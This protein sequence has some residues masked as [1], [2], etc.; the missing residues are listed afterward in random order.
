MCK[1]KLVNKVS[2]KSCVAKVST[3]N[4]RGFNDPIKQLNLVNDMDIHGIPL[5]AIQETKMSDTNVIP[6]KSDKGN[7]YSLYT[8]H[9]DNK[10]HGVGF[11]VS[12]SL[13]VK[14]NPVNNRLCYL[15]LQSDNE[16]TYIINAY[17]PTLPKS[18]KNPV[19]REN[20]Y[21]ELQSVLELCKKKDI[22]FICGDF[23]A[24][25]GSE[26]ENYSDIMG[27]FGRGKANS[28]GECLLEFC[29]RNEFILANTTFQ[30]KMSHITTWTANFNYPNTNIPV[31]NQID[32]ILINKPHRYIINNCR[33]Y[34]NI[35]TSSDH[36]PVIADL[37][38]KWIRKPG[39]T[40]KGEKPIDVE[41]LRYPEKTNAYQNLVKDKLSN[42]HN[43]S[44]PEEIWNNIVSACKTSAKEVAGEK[45]RENQVKSKRDLN[46]QRL[47]E[48]QK[49][50]GR[51]REAAKDADVRKRLQQE[52]NK[53]MRE[54]KDEVRLREE[55]KILQDIEEIEKVKDDSN[56]MYKAVRKSVRKKKQKLVIKTKDGLTCDVEEATNEI[57]KFFKDMFN[58]DH[59]IDDLAEPTP[60]N[61]P[62]A[63]SEVKK[64]IKSLKFNKSPGIDNLTSEELKMGPEELFESIASLL[65]TIA[66]TGKYPQVLNHG[67]LI[68]LQKPG[69]AKG[70]VGNLRPVILS[71]LLRKVIAICMLNR[72]TSKL[73]GESNIPV[74]QAAYR[75]GRS[76]TEH[77]L[78]LKLL[79]EKA[80]SADSYEIIILLKDLSKAFDN[81]NRSKLI[82]ILK[83]I[84]NPDELHII[85][86]LLKDTSLQI[87]YDGKLGETFKSD[88]GVPQGDGLSPIL[89]TLY[90]AKAL[91]PTSNYLSATLS[92]HS[93]STST[94]KITESINT[95]KLQ[96]SKPVGDHTYSYI[97]PSENTTDHQSLYQKP[98]PD[99]PPLP[100]HLTDHDYSSP[101]PSFNLQQQY[102]DDTCWASTDDSKINHIM[103]TV[104]TKFESFNLSCNPL[105]DELYHVKRN[106]PED[107]KECKYLGSFFDTFTDIKARKSKAMTA[108]NQY[109]KILTNTKLSLYI[110][111]RLFNAY[112]RSIFLYNSEL[113]STNKK[114]YSIID[115]FQ[116]RLYRKILQI[117]YPV[118]ISNSDLYSCF[119]E[120]P[121][122]ELIRERRLRWIGHL[123][124]LP[125]DS[126]VRIALSESTSHYKRVR[127]GQATTYIRS[128][129]S[130]LKDLQLPPVNSL[131]LSETVSDRNSF[132]R[133]IHSKLRSGE[134]RR[135]PA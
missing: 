123:H 103:N 95:S 131:E 49:K 39:N 31:R 4:V 125:I 127:G 135:D 66:S 43:V 37:S 13:N 75:P 24:K 64:A 23:N 26:F 32:Y 63:V 87:R 56:R 114:V 88:V 15:I 72:I 126:P 100:L 45:S 36:K 128:V 47:S 111:N 3:F 73:Y 109:I 11:V 83:N 17:A 9:C 77:V 6:L 8:S 41:K 44:E 14:F 34:I 54:I 53:I 22:I 74:T 28:N 27:K 133:L 119:K 89:F 82:Q 65:N 113:W 21:D 85:T 16:T 79:I 112:V 7:N 81:V 2:A 99:K 93:Y 60:M 91:G 80:I 124:R 33:S 122:S 92:D 55:E 130:D 86:I 120:K 42:I 59:S 52:R 105:K 68:P 29:K 71:T 18:E 48:K 35:F 118:V 90:L 25:T 30:H 57:T 115:V 97:S 40:E 20:F 58:K 134:Q 19:I 70:P 69:K 116:R 110:R 10:Y 46:I 51:D 104:S 61:P 107:W 129:N 62:F 38:K 102:A 12:D 96:S 108:F 84:L 132:R 50:I 101:P 98:D 67:I 106:G 117:K 76:T 5:C 78:S 1:P 94:H 121:W